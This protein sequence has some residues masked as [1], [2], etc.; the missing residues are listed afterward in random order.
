MPD[1]QHLHD[2]ATLYV[3]GQLSESERAEFESRLAHS[4]ELR[5]LVR[6][7]E[8]GSVAL[9]IAS[10]SRRPPKE[11][12]T[13]IEK[14]IASES[15]RANWLAVLRASWWR[16]GWAA[17]TAC[18]LGWLLYALWISRPASPSG[19]PV[20][21]VPEN[22]LQ[23]QSASASS[24]SETVNRVRQQAITQSNAAFR[25]LQASTQELGALRGQ[26]AELTN[27][28]G[29]LSQALVQQQALLSEPGRLKFFQLTSPSGSNGA[30]AAAISPELQRALL[31]A[32]ARE[33]GWQN[34]AISTQV[35]GVTN[36]PDWRG[37]VV[38]TNHDGVDFVDL[39]ASSNSVAAPTSQMPVEVTPSDAQ[40]SPLL[41]SASSNA[42]PGFVS[43]TNAVLAFD[44]SVVPTGSSLSFWSA[45][46][47]GQLYPIGSTTLGNYPMVVT[48]PL[49][50]SSSAGGSVTVIGGMPNGTSN[51]IGHFFAP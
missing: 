8:E 34:P 21:V 36:G 17:A 43:G 22:N 16:N 37:N 27:R 11:I 41:A 14:E 50:T 15:R 19:L 39:R 4:A 42:V 3:I 24:E 20:A 47:W 7:L 44:S 45:R 33:L 26:V 23:Q 48:I 2:Q 38:R 6:E 49:T 13:Q 10:P 30:V 12:W 40:E 1:S 29:N 18:L 51:V 5:A 32:M 35:A 28:L 9:A 46:S 25:R 31:L